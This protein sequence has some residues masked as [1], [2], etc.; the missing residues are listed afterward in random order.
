MTEA[1]FRLSRQS[2]LGLILI[3]A[4]GLGASL[5]PASAQTAVGGRPA[6]PTTVSPQSLTG[7]EV[8]PQMVSVPKPALPNV[9]APSNVSGSNSNTDTNATQASQMSDLIRLYPVSYTHL[10]LPTI[11]SV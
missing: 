1:R 3:Q 5:S 2:L 9:A 6:L 7:L 8:P 11:C 10:T 4:F